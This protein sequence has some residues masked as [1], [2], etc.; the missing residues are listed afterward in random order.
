MS[1][2]TE[3]SGLRPQ[4]TYTKN[5]KR[6]I[7]VTLNHYCSNVHLFIYPSKPQRNK[8][9]PYQKVFLYGERRTTSSFYYPRWTKPQPLFL[10]S[11][12]RVV[13]TSS[14]TTWD[15][16]WKELST[17]KTKDSERLQDVPP[18][19]PKRCHRWG[20]RR[21]HTSI[22]WDVLGER[23]KYVTQSPN[24]FGGFRYPTPR[25]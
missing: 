8:I 6:I 4:R 11:E 17:T 20:P 10:P 9:N 24:L 5:T 21:V 1:R 2:E 18:D 25:T 7:T 16:R 22:R 19:R 14:R 3:P 12:G 13:W 15:Q 23:Y